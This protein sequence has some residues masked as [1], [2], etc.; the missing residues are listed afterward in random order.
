MSQVPRTQTHLKELVDNLIKNEKKTFVYDLDEDDFDIFDNGNESF[1]NI[2]DFTLV[3]QFN[4]FCSNHLNKFSFEQLI[5]LKFFAKIHSFL[6]ST[7]ASLINNTPYDYELLL[8]NFLN[9]ID[10]IYDYLL[11]SQTI[12]QIKFELIDLFLLSTFNS[13]VQLCKYF[14]NQKSFSQKTLSMSQV[15]SRPDAKLSAQLIKASNLFESKITNLNEETNKTNLIKLNKFLVYLLKNFKDAKSNVFVWKMISRLVVKFKILLNDYQDDSGDFCQVN[16][17]FLI[18]KIFTLIYDDQSLNLNYIKDSLNRLSLNET[19]KSSDVSNAI[20]SQMTLKNNIY[21]D[22]T[23]VIKLTAFLS[24]IL[25]SFLGLYYSDLSYLLKNDFFLMFTDILGS[26]NSILLTESR[27]NNECLTIDA[28]QNDFQPKNFI[29]LPKE[30]VQIKLDF[31]KEFSSI[32][33]SLIQLIESNKDYALF[34]HRHDFFLDKI[35]QKCESNELFSNSQLSQSL[36]H[37]QQMNSLDD[38]L[39]FYLT[40]INRSKVVLDELDYSKKN[41]IFLDQIFNLAELSKISFNVPIYLLYNDQFFEKFDFNCISSASYESGKFSRIEFYDFILIGLARYIQTYLNR[42]SN[43]EFL[44]YFLTSNILITNNQIE[45][46]LENQKN[47]YLFYQFRIELSCDLLVTT[48]KW[49]M[50]SN[51]SKSYENLLKLLQFLSEVYETTGCSFISNKNMNL[52][53]VLFDIIEVCSQKCSKFANILIF[54]KDLYVNKKYANCFNLISPYL[55]KV[56]N[57]NKQAFITLALLK[58]S[59]L[60]EGLIKLFN[61]KTK[62]PNEQLWMK[63]I[64]V[65]I[66]SNHF[67]ELIGIVND[68]FNQNQE[69]FNEIITE[70]ANKT[71]NKTIQFLKLNEIDNLNKYFEQFNQYKTE[72]SRKTEGKQVIFKQFSLNFE[73]FKR[74]FQFICDSSRLFTSLSTKAQNKINYNEEIL[75]ILSFL[76]KH[77]S[78]NYENKIGYLNHEYYPT[79]LNIKIESGQFLR[80]L[81]RKEI[82][83]SNINKKILELFEVLLS[84]S[85]ILVKHFSLD[86]LDEY[87]KSNESNNKIICQLSRGNTKNLNEIIYNYL[88]EIS[89][90][91]DFNEINY[92]QEKRNELLEKLKNFQDSKDNILLS[93][94]LYEIDEYGGLDETMNAIM[95]AMDT[96]ISNTDKQNY[97]SMETTEINPDDMMAI[98]NF[99]KELDNIFLMYNSQSLPESLKNKLSNIASKI[100]NFI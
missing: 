46:N 83:D 49:L 3:D 48:T 97:D 20:G 62:T 59:E 66:D 12:T 35:N 11:K 30:Y 98:D 33:E 89:I 36:S 42:N 16:G 80:F 94:K 5:E 54:L 40:F 21:L 44:I 76:I 96:T 93:Q 65:F 99:S 8:G 72:M 7:V 31:I 73:N 56:P 70:Q 58:I 69:E 1:D 22:T 26:I 77:C 6:Y 50:N 74:I 32:Y 13:F 71:I 51:K 29:N 41:P 53:L 95:C 63:K 86:C 67:V 75:F 15:S 18:K 85:N 39:L 55:N 64:I 25:K 23:K 10:L 2:D 92:Y 87:S 47:V 17:K 34:M 84:D 24:K 4:K 45:E 90:D 68:F 43:Q 14:K 9:S 19:S 91:S 37:T 27:I 60:Y 28:N 57:S 81:A 82:N 52:K 78:L 88:V 61:D 38:L 100:T 79:F